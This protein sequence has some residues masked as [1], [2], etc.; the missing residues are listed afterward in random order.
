LTA[1]RRGLLPEL[2][3]KDTF[4]EGSSM[5]HTLVLAVGRDPVLLETRSQ[6]LQAAGYTVIPELSLKQAVARFPEG[7][8][9]LVLLCHS[10]AARDRELLT[11][12][13]RQH[14]SR[15]P[16]VTV[17]ATLCEF[18]SFTDATIGNDPKELLAGLLELLSG[19]EREQEISGKLKDVA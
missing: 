15:T 8:F 7:D 19:Q 10:I 3:S 14:T 17:A 9:D 11:Q 2:W 4:P 16:I 1:D 5:P 6:V 13:L 12:L 18:D